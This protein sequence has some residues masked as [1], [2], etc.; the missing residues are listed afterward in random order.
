MKFCPKCGG[1][2]VPVK[3]GDKI[4]LRCTKCGYEMPAPPDVIKRYKHVARPHS[5]EKVV[6][7]K[8]IS[9]PQQSELDRE[10]LEQAKEEYYE[11]VL[12][13]MGEYGE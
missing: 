12:E 7:T 5:K 11:F 3:K 8:V 1:P 6:T 9:K 4:V 13:Q 10:M 2:M